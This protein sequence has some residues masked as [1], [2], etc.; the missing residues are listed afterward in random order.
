M[1]AAL[2]IV[3]GEEVIIRRR[4][5]LGHIA[6]NR[7]KAINSLTLE[8]VRSIASALDEFAED[9]GIAAVLLT[10]EGER[11]LC[12]GGDIKAIQASA[13][14]HDGWA[15]TFWREEYRLNAVINGY[16]KPYVAIMDGVTMGGGVGLSAHA[17]HRVVTEKTRLA[18]PETGIGF[19]PDVG[20]SWLLSHA[21]GEVGTYLGLTGQ[22]IGAADT[23]LAGL[24]DHY[25]ATTRLEVLYAALEAL[26][27]DASFEQV[28]DVIESFEDAAP[29]GQLSDHKPLI[30]RFFG[31]SSMEAIIA[32]LKA[33]ES[34]FAAETLATLETRSPTSLKVTLAMLRAGRQSR[35][36]ET[37]LEREF[38][39][40]ASTV[41]SHD[42]HEG[43]RAA[44]IDKDRNP[45]WQPRRLDD[46]GEDIV[47]AY[48][49]PHV[50]PLF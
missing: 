43:V 20:A 8:M 50:R 42:F 13:S 14:K 3:A 34:A 17:S 37:C 38:G 11:G 26:P 40:T 46:V 22:M 12:A 15:E 6:L 36:L 18:M 32:G 21:P 7:P 28:G 31:E 5:T 25:V 19:F 9:P 45:K 35:D 47:E 16:S 2:D 33:D 4:G 41:I 49:T 1:N 23:M 27:A 30:D 48:L 24:A 39:G 44:V 10:G 29:E